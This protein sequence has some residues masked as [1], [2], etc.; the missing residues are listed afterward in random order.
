[1]SFLFVD[2]ILE[3]V[4]GKMCRGL[5]YVT[6]DDIYLCQDKNNKLCFSPSM[7]GEALGQLAAWNAMFSVDFKYRP[8]A[9]IVD[10]AQLIRNVYIGD[11]ILLEA[12][13][14]SVDETAIQYNAKAMVRGEEVFNIRNALGPMMPM[15]DFIDEDLILKQFKEINRYG[16]WVGDLGNSSKDEIISAKTSPQIVSLTYDKIIE[17]KSGIRIIAQKKISRQAPFFPDHFPNNP[18]LPLTV[19]L[20]C[21]IDLAHRFI[22]KSNFA[23]DFYLSEIRKIK[24][25]EF[26]HP[27]DE[28]VTSILVKQHEENILILRFRTEVLGKRVCVLEIVMTR[29][30]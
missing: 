16:D 15:Q 14:E 24:I 21:N 11:T 26:V 30:V 25:N 1:M 6:Q 22:K 27:G 29:D 4:P 19:L 18:V 8:V 3:F 9:G 12:N 10:A 13:I 28:I 2:R 17:Q 20:E 23:H 7:I 5:K